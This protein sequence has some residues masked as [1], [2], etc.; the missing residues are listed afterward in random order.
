MKFLGVDGGGT[1]TEFLIIDSNG[2]VLAHTIKPTCHYKQTSIEN[3]KSIMESGIMEL[4]SEIGISPLE[5]NY[6]IIGIPGYGEIDADIKILESIIE[7]ILLSKNFKCV[8]DSVVAWA[9]SLI[10]SPGIN[11]VA[12]TGSIGF[13]M[14][15]NGDTARVGGWGHFCGDEGSAYWLGKK[16]IELFT[17][18]SDGRMEKSPLYEIV[19][20]EF[21]IQ[22]DFEFLDLII[23]DLE[24][25]RDE[26]GQLAKLLY[27]AAEAGDEVAIKT[28]SHAS[29]EL[30][31]I[32][33][34][35][36]EKLN[37]DISSEILASYSGGVFNAGKYILEPLDMYLMKDKLNI[38]FVEPILMPVTG[39][40]LYALNIYLGNIENNALERLKIEEK[41]IF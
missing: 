17:K 9:G 40:A 19:K 22:E 31:L 41:T 23:N 8:N 38:K 30:Y 25:K 29:H 37:F 13:G 16:V 32:I 24:M 18:Q 35:L 12:G 33:K 3:F 6:S 14:N 11:I 21:N 1:K 26:I 27:R 10:C 39:A 34:A 20:E 28:Y 4:C 7:D 2:K 15:D 36:V 5:I